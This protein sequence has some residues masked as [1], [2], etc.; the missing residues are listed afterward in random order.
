[1]Q[2]NIPLT[3]NRPRPPFASV[4]FA[5]ASLVLTWETRRQTRRALSDMDA[6]LIADI[7]LTAL[8]A[9][10]EAEKPFWRA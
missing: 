7:G 9:Q 5:F 2:N 1:M 4:A 10:A 8:V 6:H 3:L